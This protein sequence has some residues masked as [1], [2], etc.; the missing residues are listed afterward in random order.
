MPRHI[1]LSD[2]VFKSR[3]LLSLISDFASRIEF[4]SV[5]VRA[6]GF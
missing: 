6:M 2:V 5:V 1:S 4:R 3:V